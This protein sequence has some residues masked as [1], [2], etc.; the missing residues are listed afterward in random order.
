MLGSCRPLWP[1]GLVEA[2]EKPRD[3]VRERPVSASWRSQ[4]LTRNS[5]LTKGLP[6]FLPGA[7]TRRL[8]GRAVRPGWPGHP[9]TT[10]D[11]KIGNK[12]TLERRGKISTF[13]TWRTRLHSG[14]CH[15]QE[16]CRPRSLRCSGADAGGGMDNFQLQACAV[17]DLT[18]FLGLEG[19]CNMTGLQ[20]R[21]A[22]K[23]S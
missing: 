2:G 21:H 5:A 22:S 14:P 1:S 11:C 4:L 17:Q 6:A 9:L 8:R 7:W 15:G 19:A 13:A 20:R 10:L 23:A 12:Q 16:S 3:A 18:Q